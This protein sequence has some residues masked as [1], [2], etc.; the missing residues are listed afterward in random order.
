[1]GVMTSLADRTI[2]ALRAEHDTTTAIADGLSDAQLSG[3]SGAADWTVADVLS[4]LGSGAEITLA[5]L[6][7]ALG[8]REA[9]AEDFNQSV[10]DRWIAMSPGQQRDGFVAHDATLVAAFEVLE[11][12]R[13]ESLELHVGFA[14]A[15]LSVAT[16][17]G[18]RLNESVQHGRDIRVSVDAAAGDGQ[19]RAVRAR[20]G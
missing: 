10:W 6:Q 20:V 5:G 1:M 15:P 19:R 11:Q 14:P 2:A 16:F 8:T 7:V 18:L 17:G 12:T 13:R 4:H 9:P 3:P